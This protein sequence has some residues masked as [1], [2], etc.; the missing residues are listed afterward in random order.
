MYFVTEIIENEIIGTPR[1]FIELEQAQDHF[2]KIVME[3]GY[4]TNDGMYK[5]D[6]TAFVHLE[7]ASIQLIEIKQR[8]TMKA[9]QEQYEESVLV[10]NKGGQYAVYDYA[11]DEGITSWTLCESCEDDTPDCEDGCCLVCGSTK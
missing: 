3:Y 10:Y 9:N 4:C 6:D 7:D 1:M 2:D 11:K 5:E 8:I